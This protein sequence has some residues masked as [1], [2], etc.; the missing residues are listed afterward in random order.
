MY[1]DVIL[2]KINNQY[3]ARA[4]LLPEIQEQGTNR[5]DVLIRI[6]QRLR[7]YFVEQQVEIV[8]VEVDDKNC[9]LDNFGLLAED[10]SFDDWQKEIKAYR[11]E[12]DS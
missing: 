1:Y 9:W 6:Q 11:Q 3:F 2:S 8:K 7:H 4:S 12:V 10:V 5:D